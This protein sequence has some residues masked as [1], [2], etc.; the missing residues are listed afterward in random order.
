[1]ERHAH[2]AAEPRPGPRPAACFNKSFTQ[3][4]KAW[5]AFERELYALR[6]GLAAVE[7]LAKGFRLHVMMDHKNSIFTNSRLGNKRVN[8]KLLLW[9]LEIEYGRCPGC[10]QKHRRRISVCIGLR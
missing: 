4:E 7:H 5:S 10:I 2:A 8:K 9:A 6:E 1:M 3:T